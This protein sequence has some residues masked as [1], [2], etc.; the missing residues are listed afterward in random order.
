M[1]LDARAMAAGRSTLLHTLPPTDSTFHTFVELQAPAAFEWGGVRGLLDVIDPADGTVRQS[2]PMTM[3]ELRDSRRRGLEAIVS[4]AGWQPGTYRVRATIS[5]GSE[6]V[7]ALTRSII[8]ETSP[9]AGA[10]T[11]TSTPAS[12]SASAAVSASTPAAT[13]P[14]GTSPWTASAADI[15]GANGV[16]P[17]AMA[18]VQDY[19]T[20]GSSVVAEEH[21][22]Q[23]LRRGP[24]DPK[25]QNVDEALEWRADH[26]LRPRNVRD[27]IKRRQLV[28]DVLMVKAR[29]GAW[30][31]YRDV[32]SVDGREVGDRSKRALRLFTGSS[33]AADSSAASNAAAGD[34]LQVKLR[35]V[36]DESSR[37]NL[38]RIGNYNVPALPLIML[39]P[40]HATRFEFAADGETTIDGVRTIVVAYRER[41][42]PTLVRDVRGDN[43]FL[44]GRLWIAAGD[45]R[46]LRTE[47]LV[48]DRHAVWSSQVIVSYRVAPTI[49][50]LMPAE[51][52]ERHT[53]SDRFREPYVEGRAVYTNFRRFSVTTREESK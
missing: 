18:Y 36:A 41:T 50:L 7:A 11:S 1:L 2:W 49:G 38:A 15:V 34:G 23:I 19:L 14:A 39:L 35:K 25:V 26:D 47:T 20:Q 31:T 4:V 12:T 33:D 21:F 40:Q 27:A 46:V 37:Y 9:P 16:V 43:V 22:V 6:P 28:S 42:G 32:G 3:R 29:S 10:S 44:T 52:W 48:E 5:N 13:S 17:R 45:G 53:P 24:P 51:M 8:L 30:T